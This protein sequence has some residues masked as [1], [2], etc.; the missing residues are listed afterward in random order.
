MDSYLLSPEGGISAL[1][2]DRVNPVQQG[3]LCESDPRRLLSRFPQLDH[4]H[5]WT[6]VIAKK[7][8]GPFVFFCLPLRGS[9]FVAYW[10]LVTSCSVLQTELKRALGH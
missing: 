5:L 8:R 4:R 9:S 10:L 6:A 1:G 7:P 2:D 3:S